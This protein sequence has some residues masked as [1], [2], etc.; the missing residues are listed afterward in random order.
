MQCCNTTVSNYS[1]VFNGAQACNKRDASWINY[2]LPSLASTIVVHIMVGSLYCTI[3]M[4]NQTVRERLT[5]NFN[6]HHTI[7]S[8]TSLNTTRIIIINY[9]KGS[10]KSKQS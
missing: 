1:F 5:V 3:R 10:P 8:R 7:F 4:S 2:L 9:F 6:E